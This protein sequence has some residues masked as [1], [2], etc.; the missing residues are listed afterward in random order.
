[1]AEDSIHQLRV[2]TK[3]LRAFLRVY[4]PSLSVAVANRD[5]KSLADSYA[6][7]RDAQVAL[8]TL[9][10][11]IGGWSD[12]KRRKHREVIDFIAHQKQQAE[13]LTEPREPHQALEQVM[14]HWP[15]T[16]DAQHPFS[17]RDGMR[18]LYEKAR[19]LGRKALQSDIDEDFHRWRKWVK[20]W[21]YC[22]T[23][24]SSGKVPAGYSKRLKRLGD[25]LG[26]FHDIC[27]LEDSLK[28]PDVYHEFG[29]GLKPFYKL[30]QAEKKR[31]K[32]SYRKAYK[33]LFRL[34][35]GQR[36]LLLGDS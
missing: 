22:L 28:S 2:C 1:M 16:G 9:N 4:P 26:V 36:D 24:L 35:P 8:A 14:L 25:S 11:L 31:M 5:L 34:D 10:R 15:G 30:I 19:R 3:R 17:A 13:A 27:V 7:V 33:K 18:R 12:K 20:Y 23:E 29:K 21:L 32:K 6:G